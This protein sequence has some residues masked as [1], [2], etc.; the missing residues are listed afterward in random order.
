[1][2]RSRTAAALAILV[3]LAVFNPLPWARAES[4]YEQFGGSARGQT[5]SVEAGR[6]A[7]SAA[8]SAPDSVASGGESS[9]TPPVR[10]WRA[11]PA[12]CATPSLKTTIFAVDCMD[13]LDR[14]Y[15]GIECEKGQQALGALFE[16][17]LGP[18][19]RLETVM[20][21]EESCV[22]EREPEAD[23]PAAA[24]RAFRQMRITPSQMSV[25]PP[26]GWTLVNVDTI[27]FTEAAPRTMSTRLFD[28]PVEIRAVP[29]AYSW[30]F[31]DGSAPVVTTDPGAPYPAH[32]VSHAYAR[33]GV[34]TI[35]LTTTWRGQFRP[36]GDSVWRDVPG[37][38]TTV[39]SSG[40]L[41]ILEARARLVEDLYAE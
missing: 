40:D 39:S 3:L 12:M 16:E 23:I 11:T 32:T 20:L 7:P 21:E 29:S 30:N 1:M 35:S 5:I 26:D 25:Q 19:G 37:E 24:A 36:A 33:Q 8:T 13:G 14:A 2:D 41:E 6:H 28:V 10:R 38:A 22:T 17:R 9:A 18:S 34:V 31:G 27:V 15:G 4:P